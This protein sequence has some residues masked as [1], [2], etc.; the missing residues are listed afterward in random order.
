VLSFEEAC[1]HPQITSRELL[2]DVPKEDGSV[3]RQIASPIKFSETTPEYHY[4]G[5]RLGQHTD[6]IL[7]DAGYAAEDI[8]RMK[9]DRSVM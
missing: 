3:Q 8:E 2:V 1:E 4:I 9:K 6:E 7:S 5:A